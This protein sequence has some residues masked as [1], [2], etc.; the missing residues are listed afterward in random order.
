MTL[1]SGTVMVLAY[2]LVSV[3]VIIIFLVAVF[4]IARFIGWLRE[5]RGGR[6]EE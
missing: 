1:D 5:R 2:L 4:V 3:G 6:G